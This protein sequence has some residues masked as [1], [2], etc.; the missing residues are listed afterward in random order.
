MYWPPRQIG[1][2]LAPCTR[3]SKFKVPS[4]KLRVEMDGAN[5]SLRERSRAIERVR[6]HGD[7]SVIDF[8]EAHYPHREVPSHLSRRE[9][10]GFPPLPPGEVASYRAGEGSTSSTSSVHRPLHR[11]HIRPHR[12]VP[13]HLSRRER[14][15][16]LPFTVFHHSPLN[17][18]LFPV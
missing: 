3:S 18:A 5:L 1:T 15:P 14:L 17:F 7:E 10:F 9:R 6:A 13:S 11:Q 16:Y 2:G 8:T 4:S 12:E